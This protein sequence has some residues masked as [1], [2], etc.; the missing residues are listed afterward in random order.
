MGDN[1]SLLRDLARLIPGYGA[2]LDQESRRVDDRITREFLVKRLADCKSKLDGVG[3]R[4]AESGNFE[5]PLKLEKLRDG[6]DLAQRRL[7][8]AVEGYASWFGERTVDAELLGEVAQL[9]ANLVSLVDQLDALG[10]RLAED[11][12]LDLTE[13]NQLLDLLHKRIDRRNEMIQSGS[14]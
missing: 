1:D 8:A 10:E 4:L 2:Y 6:M 7:A 14:H 11:P 5:M 13:F 9:D 12:A 3:K